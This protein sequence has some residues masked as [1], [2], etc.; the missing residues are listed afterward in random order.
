MAIG[1]ATAAGDELWL[2]AT[3]I[4]AARLAALPRAAARAMPTVG[5]QTAMALAECSY[6][7]VATGAPGRGSGGG[8]RSTS[9]FPQQQFGDATM[10]PETAMSLLPPSYYL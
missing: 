2:A 10:S 8:L 9:P 4:A 5:S 3:Q 1:L 6:D 7:T